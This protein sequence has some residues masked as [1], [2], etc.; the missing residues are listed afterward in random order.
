MP[1]SH[2]GAH[3]LPLFLLLSSA[4]AFAQSLGGAGTL[5][6]T[7]KDASDLPVPEAAVELSNSVSGF[8]RYARTGSAG[9]FVI[10]GIPPNT[11]RLRISQ[12]GFQVKDLGTTIRMSIPIDLTIRLDLATQQ[13]TISVEASP[14]NLVENK[15]TASGIVDRRL[16]AALPSFSPDSGLNDA[17]I[18]TTPGVV[19]DSNGF[20]HPLGD[21]AQV[22]YVIDGQPVSDQRNKVFSTS[23]PANAIQ[24]MEVISGSPPAEYGDKTSLVINA[25]SRSGLGQKPT[26]SLLTSYGSF[27]TLS[28]EATLG[29]GTA[30]WGNFL[31]MNTARTGRFLDTPEFW[32]MHDTG[33]TG[34]FFD[35]LDFQPTGR[36][37]VHLNLMLARNWMQVPNT[38]DQSAQDQK[39]KV[40]SFNVAPGY[41]H[42]VDAQTLVSVNACFRRDRVDYY[43]SRNPLD[44]SPATLAQDRS[45]TNFGVHSD[46]S[47][48]QGR[49]NWKAGLNAAQT[50][51]DE[52]FSL[53]ITSPTYNSA[54]L[55]GGNPV[56]LRAASDPSLCAAAGF[57]PNPAFLSGLLPYDLTR[58]GKP[59]Q[60]RGNANINQLAL[61]GQDSITLG[62]LTLNL[63]V[64]FDRYDGLTRGT[65]IQPRGAFSYLFKPTNTVIRGG[66]SHTME[67]PTNENLVASSSTGSGGLASNLFKGAAEERPI[68]L[69]S[70]N[71][72]DA[73]IQ[74]SIGKWL[75]VDVS[76]FRKYTRNAFDFDALFSTPITFPIGWKQSK[77]DGVTAR[78]STIDIHGL[79][80]DATMGHANARF[81]G[82]ENGGIIFNSNLTVGAYRQDHDQVYQ[83]NVNLH[84][85]PTRNGWWA[86]FTWR[87]DSGLV[88]G[89][90][91]S[92]Q[93]ALALS[94]DQQSTIGLYCGDERAS[95][96][97]R[98][99]ACNSP[100]YGAVRINILPPGTENDDRN[101]PRT[102]SRH[103]F[104]LGAGTDN[105]FHAER[106]RTM[107]HFTILNLTNE[108]ALYNFLSPFSGTHLVEPRVY[109]MQLGWAF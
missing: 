71:Q 94:A 51:L 53:G 35:R 96:A 105:L 54:C 7:V 108:A 76:Y 84:Y 83:Q 67:T 38:Y 10:N 77:L 86:G 99:T 16:L 80:V 62:N 75:L 24:S 104:S 82:P 98:I 66:F 81:F 107:V 18:Q 68:A 19:A 20:F 3:A 25:T 79:R 102:K 22:S 101:P 8:S 9:T 1:K 87:Y 109:Q 49:H 50:Q 57:Q 31:A 106:L 85:Q 46:L 90:V 59:Y 91:N 58:G 95:L 6:G 13:T 42:T 14:E 63:G 103:I 33:N 30:R 5:R 72:Y 28:E 60:F 69:G 97:H 56:P 73:G 36:D 4:Q 40:V 74:Q 88:V 32:P 29:S 65:G 34:T 2:W 41:Q 92:L 44:D 47:R 78:F 61:F 93:N 43:P 64:R 48:V 100:D 23:I 27:G 21:H 26:G 12:P 70:R 45:L 11:Y 15:A 37:A 17:I 89:A 52:E 55:S 39:Q